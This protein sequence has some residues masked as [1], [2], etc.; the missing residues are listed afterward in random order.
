M[1]VFKRDEGSFRD[2]SGYV[3][4]DGRR[5][6]RTVQPA[7]LEAFTA[8]RNNG[9][10]EK[11]IS[12]GLMLSF[13]EVKLVENPYLFEGARGEHPA[14]ILEQPKLK[15][16]TY[17]YEWT[18]GQ[19]KDAAIAHLDL[20]ITLIKEG[21]ELSDASAFNMQFHAGKFVHVDLLSI[22][23]YQK[24]MPWEGYNQ[25]CRHFLFPLLLD[26]K[27]E[28]S[29]NAMTRASLE[30]ISVSDINKLLPLHIKA[31][32]LNTFLHVVLHNKSIQSASSTASCKNPTTLPYFSD[33]KYLSILDGLRDWI[34]SLDSKAHKHSYW[35]EYAKNNS[36]D[37]LER[38]RKL[39]F[40]RDTVRNWG[41]ESTADIGGNSGD[42]SI[43]ALEGG[44]K[45]V[46]L[47]D[48][49]LGALNVAYS[50]TVSGHPDLLPIVA[51]WAD[52]PPAQ[53]WLAKE[54]KALSARLKCDC[55][56]ALAIIHHICI[57]ANIPMREFISSIFSVAQKVV[58]EFVPKSDPMVQGLLTHRKDVFG[59]YTEENFL[60]Y[61]SE[62]AI[63]N[64]QMRFH[65]GGRLI[66][67]CEARHG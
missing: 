39:A 56:L 46:Y 45:N 5:I 43:A 42:F 66:V 44:S 10:Y 22:R 29:F 23:K 9:V 2:P 11:A 67:S 25:F 36:Y 50:R 33:R 34:S 13:E 32:S 62:F 19:L 30:G 54:R 35:E 17:P 37:Q 3:F 31:T 60:K 49:D 59:D 63:I 15:M 47:I 24:G 55:V 6:I 12:A 64:R 57:S 14:V 27:L 65:E 51:N 20:Q 40:V 26:S 41:C 4:S 28:V 58:L 38:E 52:M 1:S 61:I 8:A 18:F 48:S 53:G 16:V 7:G 21:F